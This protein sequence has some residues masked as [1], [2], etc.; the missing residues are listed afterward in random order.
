MLVSQGK[1][2][3]KNILGRVGV[4]NP[5]DSHTRKVFCRSVNAKCF[6][7]LQLSELRISKRIKYADAER[8]PIGTS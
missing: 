1:R 6:A 7:K 8:T 5:G 3:I 2:A 4:E